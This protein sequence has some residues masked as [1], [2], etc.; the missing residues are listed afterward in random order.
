MIC[1]TIGSFLPSNISS[2]GCW[3]RWSPRSYELRDFLERNHVPYQW[4]DVELSA[5]DPEPSA[6]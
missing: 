3:Y 1:S 6:L 2:I 5:N 4:I